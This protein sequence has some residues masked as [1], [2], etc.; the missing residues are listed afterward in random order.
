LEEIM[1]T[2]VL[3]PF[4]LSCV[5]AGCG[6]AATSSDSVSDTSALANACDGPGPLVG[7]SA[8]SW[9]DPH[10]ITPDGLQF[11]DQEPG[12]H[13]EVQSRSARDRSKVTAGQ[14]QVA[15]DAYACSTGVFCNR[16]VDVY[17]AGNRVHLVAGRPGFIGVNGA[18]TTVSSPV[19]LGGGVT[20]AN[21]PTPA[22]DPTNTY[23]LSNSYGE[24]VTLTTLNDFGHYIDIAVTLS[25]ARKGDTAGGILGC[26]DADA[27]PSNDLCHRFDCATYDPNDS[28]QVAAFIS[29][30]R[31]LA[32]DDVDTS[33]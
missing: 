5:L 28:A 18:W 2:E 7:T 3:T 29:D 19:Q 4:L 32:D 23:T 14:L 8:L 20:L 16:A 22:S 25:S 6:S 24:T 21:V 10:Q 1:K 9:G 12:W 31:I 27:D 33:E 17:M 26:F 15:A 11:E 30:W 13:I